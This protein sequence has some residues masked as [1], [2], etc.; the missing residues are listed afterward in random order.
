MRSTS[1]W[2]GKF[3]AGALLFLYAVL[4]LAPS[5][6]HSQ[7]PLV[8]TVP[9]GAEPNGLALNPTTNQAVITHPEANRVTVVEL[10]TRTRP[11]FLW[12]RIPG[13]WRSTPRPTGPM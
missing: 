7:T 12:V 11:R 9:V 3:S 4:L 1:G 6:L 13:A 10:A 8:V 5:S 2:V